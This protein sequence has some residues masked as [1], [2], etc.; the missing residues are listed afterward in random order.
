MILCNSRNKFTLNRNYH[1]GL[2]RKSSCFRP[3]H[4]FFDS[5]SYT[6]IPLICQDVFLKFSYHS[7]WIN[8]LK[9]VTVD[10]LFFKKAKAFARAT[11]PLPLAAHSLR[12]TNYIYYCTLCCFLMA[13]LFL[14]AIFLEPHLWY[15]VMVPTTGMLWW[16]Q[17]IFI[18]H[19]SV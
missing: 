1:H 6:S 5:L 9:T 13:F 18:I 8:F 4:I 14:M 19:R 2:G 10:F 15:L 3:D 7:F 12:T 11:S 16:W 17:F